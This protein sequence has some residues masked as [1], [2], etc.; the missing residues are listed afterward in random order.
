MAIPMK[1]GQVLRFADFEIDPAS[2][3]VLRG[4]NRLTLN[5]RAFDVLYFMALHS[6]EV[7][8]RE[9]LLRGVWPDSHVDANSLS[10]SIS[11]LRKA[12]EEKPGENAYIATLPGRG[13]QFLAPVE[14]VPTAT[15]TGAGLV[16]HQE[17]SSL[18]FEERTFSHHVVTEERLEERS[19]RRLMIVGGPI[20]AMALC[21][22]VGIGVWRARSESGGGHV[23]AV[24][25]DLENDTG[26]T[27]FDH[28]LNK[29]LQIDL[30][31]SPYF[32]VVSEGRARRTLKMMRQDPTEALT[33]PLAREV[34]Q[35]VNGQVYVVPAIA[36]LGDR[37]SLTMQVNACSDGHAL[38]SDRKEV[39]S[40]D[41]VLTAWSDLTRRVRRSA[42]ESR[43]SIKEF[44]KPLY[45]EPTSS[46]DALRAYSEA[47]RLG[48]GGKFQE[49]IALYQHAVELDPNFAVAYADMSTMYYN[50]DDKVHDKTAI[51]KAYAIRDTVNERER[52]YIELRYAQS[53]TG[54]LNA[55]LDS[56]HRWVATYPQ[57]N[58][59]L[60]DLVNFETWTGH[61]PEAAAY[62]D[63]VAELEQ[64]QNIHNGISYEIAARAY[65]HANLP[66]K[67]RA[68]Y[69]Q[70]M[71][72]K[73]DTQG[74]HC[75]MLEFAA[76]NGDQA[77]VDRQIAWS[78]NTPAEAHMLQEAG[79]AALAAGQAKKAD[80]LFKE[81]R[82]AATRDK[83]ED[84]MPDLDDYYVRM[85][86][87]V[88]LKDRAREMLKVLPPA[89]PSLDRAFTQAEIGDDAAALAAA[90]HMR[91][92]S[93]QDTL[94]TAEYVPSVQAVIALQQNRASDAVRLME[95]SSPF[96]LRDPTIPYLRGQAYLAAH[97]SAEALREFSE[98][99]D[100]PYL[101]DPSA[102]LTNLAHLGEAR[103]Y[104]QEHNEAQADEQYAK[105]FAAWSAAD[106]DL[107][108]LHEARLEEQRTRH[109]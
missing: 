94:V 108:I 98:L 109:P 52:F 65:H 29:V 11:A 5:R 7:L 2:R 57:D 26:D 23:T 70:A 24:L 38:G 107:P 99:A 45:D 92:E 41:K 67:V 82:L 49:S 46:L 18:V 32:G 36:K 25:A 44:D 69:A 34:C 102:A 43:S 101:A 54:D 86:A 100:R 87:E 68:T 30:Q 64:S 53:V 19:R 97:Q 60:S 74:L 48:D 73:V 66:D 8:S 78:R 4:G 84:S 81:A 85:L 63:R 10:Q 93:P 15:D 13:Y 22:A 76:E 105:F 72:W 40:K 58:L 95:A 103:A 12:L 9:E 39:A 61:Y 27:E 89:D 75:V 1:N 28:T 59:P 37:Y 80:G 56:L 77:E 3:S 79:L 71:Q 20:A 14:V 96:E 106:P 31:Q 83:V 50:I 16:Q 90:E 47:T 6:G 62:A 91:A 17:P 21:V 33:A 51:A 104:A 42:G 55:L 35:R 88:G